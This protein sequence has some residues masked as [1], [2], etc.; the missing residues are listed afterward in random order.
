MINDILG[1][2][3][4]PITESHFIKPPSGTYMVYLEDIS[5]DGS[6]GIN[7]IYIHDYALEVYEP[8][9]DNES[10]AIIE[11]ALNVAGIS[12]AKNGRTWLAEEQRYMTTYEFT[13]IEKRGFKNE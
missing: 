8:S 9:K 6:D 4:I 11:N 5:T 10:I 2:L 7:A 12:W 13:I 1:N 3:G